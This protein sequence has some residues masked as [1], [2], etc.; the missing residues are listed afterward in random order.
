MDVSTSISI[1]VAFL[2]HLLMVFHW[3]TNHFHP[4]TLN[5]NAKEALEVKGHSFV[6]HLQPCVGAVLKKRL[7]KYACSSSN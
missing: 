6:G 7:S 3:L 2:K 5:K 4:D 1:H